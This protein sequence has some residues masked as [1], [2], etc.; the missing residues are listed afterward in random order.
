[1]HLDKQAVAELRQAIDA[2]IQR[3]QPSGAPQALGFRCNWRLNFVEALKAVYAGAKVVAKVTGTVATGG[4]L[5]PLLLEVPGDLVDLLRCGVRAVVQD[6]EPLSYAACVVLGASDGGMTGEELT[7]ALGPFLR[8]CATGEV[9]WWL[10]LSTDQA[11]IAFKQLNAEGIEP[12]IKGL[13]KDGWVTRS[14]SKYEVQQKHFE[15]GF[16]RK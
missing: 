2:A 8:E 12:V 6:L 10:R 3:Q 14:G 13:A 4:A 5:A 16:Q 9:A 7:A 1:M 15:W 11:A